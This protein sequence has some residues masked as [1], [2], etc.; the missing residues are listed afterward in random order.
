MTVFWMQEHTWEEVKNQAELN[1]G[2]F[3]IPVGSTE[4]H[5][6]HLPVGTDTY[7]AIALASDASARTGAI[8]T[9]PLWFGWSPHHLALP[10][11][12]SVRAEIL[13]ELL[14]DVFLSLNRHGGQ[15][16]VVIN[17]HRIV[18][19]PWMQLAAQQAQERLGVTVE[20]FDPAYM[21][22]EIKGEL[23]FG[24]IGHAEEIE[25]SYMLLKYPELCKMDRCLD[26]VPGEPKPLYSV[27]PSY[28]G[29]TLCYVPSTSRSLANL[30][31]QS[32]GI[33]GRPSLA[34]NNRGKQYHEHLVE[35]LVA[36]INRL[37]A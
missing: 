5:G 24:E 36:I 2:V 4:Q 9:P 11:T 21:S 35:R 25:T 20:I 22:K 16:F 30:V 6:P 7:V 14:Q 10:G 8:I 28:A 33:N 13:S 19:L 32:K 37:M 31:P 15:K 23:G 26:F 27:D 3:L 29:D 34:S 18:N 12:I 17:G 1:K